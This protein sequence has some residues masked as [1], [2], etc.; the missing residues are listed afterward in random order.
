VE[1][2]IEQ[3][4]PGRWLLAVSG[5]RDS[6]VLLEAMRKRRDVVAVAT[7]DHGTG[8]TATR[9]ADCVER[10]CARFE[11]KCVRGQGKL[12]GKPTEDAL[13]KSRW[14]FLNRTAD[15]LDAR[16]VT[17]HTLD[18]HAETTFIR[19]LRDAHAR[20][21]AGMLVPSA[22]E[23]PLLLVKRA[24][25][26]AYAKKNDVTWVQDPSNASNVHLRNRVRNE[27]LP[28]IEKLKPGFTQWLLVTSARGAVWRR[29]LSD[30]VD[31]LTRGCTPG[32]IPISAME[33]MTPEASGIVWPEVASRVG[34]S[35]DWRGIERLVK[36]ARK[37]KRGAEIPL[38]GGVSFGR[39]ETTYVFRNPR[40][41]GPLY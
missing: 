36:E 20:G 31:H 16:V 15:R 14:D 29:G 23:R 38:S 1:A 26:A 17:A 8:P 6:M 2:A 18:D 37:L 19:I 35:L 41:G 34:V 25:I 24:D 30:A 40:G 11:I 9:A 39:T 33:G 12:P 5:G 4:K 27:I 22:V 21:I 7:F 28:T 32:T 3:L 10:E 13:R